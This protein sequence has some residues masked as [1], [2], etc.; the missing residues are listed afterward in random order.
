MRRG[1]H[2]LGDPMLGTGSLREQNRVVLRERWYK[3]EP[4][5]EQFGLRGAP[6]LRLEDLPGIFSDR[7]NLKVVSQERYQLSTKWEVL[8]YSI[9]GNGVRIIY[10]NQL[11]EK[12]VMIDWISI[13]RRGNRR[14]ELTIVNDRVTYLRR[15]GGE[16]ISNPVLSEEEQGCIERFIAELLSRTVE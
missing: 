3:Q 8:L 9:K 16:F 6:H 10:T 7:R 5:P 15:V 14:I 11:T 4:K 1:P 2:R 13:S 12:G